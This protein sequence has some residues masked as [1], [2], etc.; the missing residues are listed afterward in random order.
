MGSRSL[1]LLLDTHIL[2]W[3][4]EGSSEL[5]EPTVGRLETA[6]RKAGL[7]VSVISFW[8]VAMLHH[9]QRISLS[10]PLVSWR[11][12]V[13]ETPGFIEAPLAGD[14]AIESVNL[15][16]ELHG[17]PADRILIATARLNGWTLVTRD[18]RV[19]DYGRAGNVDVLEL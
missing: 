4:A 1:T 18:D 15:P 9:R 3:F 5:S 10:L 14:I 17:D 12:I 16:G 7:A 19:L 8:E 11:D 6:A 13:L 2:I